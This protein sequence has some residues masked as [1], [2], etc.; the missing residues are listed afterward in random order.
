MRQVTRQQVFN[1]RVRVANAGVFS[2]AII[3]LA[4][5]SPN[6]YGTGTEGITFKSIILAWLAF[7]A[8]RGARSATILLTDSTLTVRGLGFTKSWPVAQV[9]S[10]V[11]ETRAVTPGF[12]SLGIALSFGLLY[13]VRRPRRM[14]GVKFRNGGTRWLIELKSRTA[15]KGERTWVDRQADI[16]NNALRHE[17]RTTKPS[18]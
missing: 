7:W 15:G 16:L 18:A 4:L 2:A 17:D 5:I 1:I 9:D 14:L 3:A 13:Y 11:T 6:T 8:V 12:G 10:F